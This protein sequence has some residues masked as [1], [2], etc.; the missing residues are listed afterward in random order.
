MPRDAVSLDPLPCPFC[1]AVSPQPYIGGQC[2][3]LACN[4]CGAEGPVAHG[5]TGELLSEPDL[6]TRAFTLWNG[7]VAPQQAAR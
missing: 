6:E 7:R 5:S 4:G 3:W 1:G 2:A